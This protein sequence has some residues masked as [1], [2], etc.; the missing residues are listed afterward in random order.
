M[1]LL[2]P[3]CHDGAIWASALAAALLPSTPAWNPSPGLPEKR[4]LSGF[5]WFLCLAAY[6]SYV[7]NPQLDVTLPFFSLLSWD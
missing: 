1:T 3:C 5:F 2:P 6:A 4:C 7:K